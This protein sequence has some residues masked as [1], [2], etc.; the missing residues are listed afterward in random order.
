MFFTY[1]IVLVVLF[2]ITHSVF[3]KPSNYFIRTIMKMG[4]WYDAILNLFH[5]GSYFPHG[6][7]TVFS[8]STAAKVAKDNQ[9]HG[10][11]DCK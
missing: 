4:E 7:S 10:Q 3:W 9:Q 6:A 5:E 1:T 2:I 11:N 8:L